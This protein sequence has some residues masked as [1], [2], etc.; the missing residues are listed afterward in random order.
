[1]KPI[2][3]AAAL[4]ILAT[5]GL[6]RQ[7]E[8]EPEAACISHARLE[9]IVIA[10]R[11]E[12]LERAIQVAAR[13]CGALLVTIDTPGGDLESTRRIAQAF[14][15][16][17]IP[18]IAYVSPPGARAG[19][20]GVFLVLASHIAAMAPGTNIGAAHPVAGSGQDIE[21]AAGEDLAAKIENDA[22]AFARSL[23]EHRGRNVK[24]AEAVV[25][26]SLS[27]TAS[28]ALSDDAIDLVSATRETLLGDAAAVSFK[29][30]GETTRV[31]LSG[32]EVR[33]VDMTVSESVRAGLGHPSAVYFFL[34]IGL[35]GIVVE[36]YNPGMLV[37]GIGGGLFLLLA[38]IGSGYLPVDAAGIGLL[39]LAAAFMVA[40][41][42]ITSYGLLFA[43]GV[44]LL[45]LGSSMWL[46][47]SRPEFFADPSVE[48]SWA[49]IIP[50]VA[51]V[52][53][54]A[55]V[56]GFQI[57]R[58]QRRKPATG[59]ESMIGE[60][61]IAVTEVLGDRG[62]VRLG[63]ELWSARSAR[64]IAAGQ[65]VEVIDVDGLEL[66]VRPSDNG[67]KEEPWNG[68]G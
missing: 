20:A 36:L 63:G 48:L 59:V 46:D 9:G 51:V 3:I 58:A 37:P 38:A 4:A 5:L 34:M 55:A 33:E 21:E 24:W 50:T 67:P 44:G 56:L 19:S 61:G 32:A 12:Y 43:T 13:R 41:L 14:L 17:P 7:A 64:P 18:V 1:M 25:R 15:D 65:P 42:F 26:E 31:D 49:L 45:L 35:L 8:A 52:S 10:P 53:V 60:R 28:E 54:A 11:A 6:A 57:S 27:T 62:S 39:A 30:G 47:T 68:A 23:A 2:W 40:E 29:L 16:A 66:L 22:A